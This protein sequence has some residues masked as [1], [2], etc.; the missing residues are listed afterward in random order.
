IDILICDVCGACCHVLAKIAKVPIVVDYSSLGFLDPI[1]SS[2]HRIPNPLAYIPQMGTDYPTL[3]T[4]S[5]RLSNFLGYVVIILFKDYVMAPPFNEILHQ[6]GIVNQ[7][8]YIDRSPAHILL[9]ASD[10]AIEFPRPITPGV[11]MIGPVTVQSPQPLPQDIENFIN[12]NSNGFIF[13]S[14][15]T[16][17]VAL[18]AITDI[19]EMAKGLGQL[20]YNVLWK[21]TGSPI[22]NLPTNIKTVNWAPQNDVL[23]HAKIKAFVS[24]CGMNSVLEAAYHGVPVIAVPLMYDQSNNAQKLA[25]AGMS[26]I[27]NFRYLNAKSIKQIINDV[28]SD[29]TYAKNAK[30]VSSIMKDRPSR[31]KPIQ[32]AADWIEYALR[33]DGC[34]HL[35]SQEM[36]MPFYQRYLLDVIGFIALTIYIIYRIMRISCGFLCKRCCAKKTKQD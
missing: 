31:R 29:P 14:F 12:S 33:F 16:V 18:N 3:M 11:K 32:E 26:K 5:Q 19:D 28:V 4:F 34:E 25:V 36:N 2:V 24:H 20:P 23:G 15:G 27:I 6:H 10:F 13:V 1:V 21:Y 17:A 22:K 8:I 7:D 30:R 35:R 9:V